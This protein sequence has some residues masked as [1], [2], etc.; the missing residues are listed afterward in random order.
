LG[1]S[2]KAF[3]KEGKSQEHKVK[4]LDKNNEGGGKVY[5]LEKF[6][7]GEYTWSRFWAF[8]LLEII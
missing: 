8:Y 5:A 6:E 2:T 4:T 1:S 3:A 7:R